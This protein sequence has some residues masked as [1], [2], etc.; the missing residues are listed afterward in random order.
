M[1]VDMTEQLQE[2]EDGPVHA[3]RD[4]PATH[5][6]IGPSGVYS[7]WNDTLFLY[8][9]M[10][11]K[12]RNEESPKASGVFGRLS[13]HADG[14]RSGDQFSVYICDRFVVPQ[15][16]EEQMQGLARGDRIL[17][18]LTKQYIRDHLTY[19]VV[20]TENGEAARTLEA[21]IRREGLPNSGRPLINP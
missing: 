19:R 3:F 9:G 11:Y 2:L 6:Q 5:F 13:T 10:A 7:I 4:W 18:A 1:Q 12:H 14:R 16:T 8:V 21:L 15:L 17:D 20:V